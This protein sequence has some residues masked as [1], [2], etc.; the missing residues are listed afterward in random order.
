MS[1]IIRT[2]SPFFIRTPQETSADLSYFQ[3][4]IAILSGNYAATLPECGR[5]FTE[6][7][8]LNKKP[9]NSEDSVTVDISQIV[10]NYF[11]QNYQQQALSQPYRRIQSLWVT[12]TTKPY[13]ADGTAITTG[14]S[15]IYL[16]Q[17]GYNKFSEGVNYTIEPNAMLTANYI[18]YNNG[19]AIEIPVN[20]EA[21]SSVDFKSGNTTISTQSVSDTTSTFTKILYVDLTTSSNITS[22]V[23]TYSG[24]NTRTII[25]ERVDECKYPVFTCKFLNRWGAYQSVNFFKKSTESLETQKENYNRSIFNAAFKYR[26]RGGDGGADNPCENFFT[27]NTYSANEHSNKTYNTNGTETLELNTGFVSEQ[28]NETFKELIVSEYV[29]LTDSSNNTY[30]VNLKDSSLTY[31]TAL[32]DKMINYTMSFEKS[33][34]YI[35]NVR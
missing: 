12:V 33:F 20:V 19:S 18:Q 26:T 1:T 13:K 27:Y 24:S 30:P 7:I 35:N 2:R 5:T 6:T 10:N 3:I 15:I 4:Q 34:S 17:E 32:N 21:V 16:A 23:I 8:T 28:M 31:K 29:Y 9:I 22:I 14:T 25:V 11:Q